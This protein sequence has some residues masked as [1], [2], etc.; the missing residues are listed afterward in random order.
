VSS[1]LFGHGCLHPVCLALGERLVDRLGDN[2][3]QGAV[4]FSLTVAGESS[5]RTGNPVKEE[6]GIED[7]G[8]N[9]VQS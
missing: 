5:I 7:G 1:A 4:D 3:E 9:Q 2:L 8:G 6:E